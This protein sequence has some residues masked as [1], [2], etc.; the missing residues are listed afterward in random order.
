MNK[1]EVEH[2][3]LPDCE[4]ASVSGNTFVTCAFFFFSVCADG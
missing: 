1:W 4:S 3:T 2:F